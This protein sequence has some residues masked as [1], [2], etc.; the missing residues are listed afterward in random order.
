[1]KQTIIILTG[2]PGSGKTTAAFFYKKRKIPVVRMGD[3]T[4]NILKKTHL[5]LSWENE[6][7]VKI[8]VRIELGEDIYAKV[9]VK[10]IKDKVFGAEQVIIE[11]LRTKEELIY[12]RRNFV[13]IK[14]IYID[15]SSQIRYERLKRRRVR[16]QTERQSKS[17]DKLEG[18]LLGIENLKKIAEVKVSN[19]G[20]KA[21][22]YRKLKKISL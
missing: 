20:T 14:L 11:G 17:R 8:K 4:E 18:K 3:L 9:A 2:L 6:E 16:P 12:F 21:E 13:K 19:E 15:A 5:S 10:E 1:M 22:F 7:Y